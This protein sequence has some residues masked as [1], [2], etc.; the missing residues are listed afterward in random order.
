LQKL[1]ILVLSFALLTAAGVALG[2]QSPLPPGTHEPEG[3][4][5]VAPSSDL[6]NAEAKLS[7]KDLAGARAILDGYLAKNPADE[8]ALFD[9]GYLEDLSDH[10]EQAAAAYRKAIQIDPKHMEAQ[11]ALG[12]LLAREGKPEDARIFVEAATSLEPSSG[13]A[14]VKARAWRALAQLDRTTDPAQ[15]K[16]ALL[17][18]LKISPETSDDTLLTAEI[19]EASDDPETAEAA[20]RRVLAGQPESSPA[21]AGLVH[22][23]LKEKKYSEAE[24]ILHSALQRDPDDAALNSQWAA[25][26]LAEDKPKEAI[27]TLEKLYQLSPGDALVTRMLAET[28][29]QAKEYARADALYVQLIAEL[30]GDADLLTQHGESLL[31]QQKNADAMAAF[32]KA[33]K[34]APENTDALSG[35]AIAASE[36]KQYAMTLEALSMRSKYA[37]DTPAT[38]F[39]MATAYDSLHQRKSAAEYYQKF[40]AAA[41]GNFP[42]Q[43]WQAKHRLIA[44]GSMH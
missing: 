17:E 37:A 1:P 11:L 16:H 31:H 27:A 42:D 24:P 30:P 44:L 15:A 33:V 3:A 22:L 36:M 9:L 10:D 20:Y 43:E 2:Q 39:L 32:Q 19:A 18:A 7:Q 38:Y 40:L 14:A 28:L 41:Q 21:T 4:A 29:F 6:A 34:L 5:P 26:L 13:D 25:L 23:L 8:R 12:L 35:L